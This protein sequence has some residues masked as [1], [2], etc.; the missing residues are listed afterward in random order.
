MWAGR[1]CALLALAVPATMMA[2]GNPRACGVERWP[3]KVALDAGSSRV[4]PAPRRTTIAQ[5]GALARPASLPQ[6]ERAA[7]HELET[8]RVVAIVR[9]VSRPENDGDLH[10]VLE[11][12]EDSTRTMVA[13]APDSACA[14]GS[15]HIRAFADAYRAARTAPPRAIVIVDG[16]GFFDFLHGQGGAAPNGFE[17]H[18]I[19]S[20]RVIGRAVGRP[21]VAPR[22]D[23]SRADS[24]TRATTPVWVNT[25]SGVY[26]CAGSR[27]YGSTKRGRYMSEP[28][29]IAAG[30]RPAYGR[31]CER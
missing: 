21:A 26:H 27:W 19:L 24:V 30:M 7:P 17:L 25:S 20:L 29:A 3:V 16:I 10:L 31:R 14:L 4:D 18:P 6:R 28:D 13:E 23:P 22:N 9:S 8:F 15:P 2:Q 1:V 5:L 11:D 12:L